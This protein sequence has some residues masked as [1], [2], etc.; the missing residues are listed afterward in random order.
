MGD[1]TVDITA[2]LVGVSSGDQTILTSLYSDSPHADFLR[3][4]FDV[5]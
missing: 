3:G 5:F 4:S 2:A 1:H